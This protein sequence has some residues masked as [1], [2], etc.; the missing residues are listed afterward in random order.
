MGAVK[1]GSLKSWTQ[2]EITP[3]Q[4]RRHVVIADFLN[5]VPTCCG[6]F[7]FSSVSCPLAVA[8]VFHVGDNRTHSVSVEE[9]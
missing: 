2:C 3:N 6:V 7:V 8:M 9:I 5:P 1:S 4:A